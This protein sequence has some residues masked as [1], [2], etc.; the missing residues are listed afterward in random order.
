M[1]EFI[2][3]ILALIS[4][5]LLGCFQTSYILGRILRDLDIRQHGSSNAGASNAVTILGFRWGLVTFLVDFCKAAS[6]VW[7]IR[8]FFPDPPV[9]S[10]LAGAAAV[11]GHIFP[12]FLR[13]R[14]GKGVAAMLGMYMAV[15]PW[16]GVM[17]LVI[18][19]VIAGITD[20]VA[21]GSLAFFALLPL[22]TYFLGYGPFGIGLSILL[23]IIGLVKHRENVIRIRAG[24][25]VKVRPTLFKSCR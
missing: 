12:F 8:W 23:M 11:L 24:T 18:Q 17:I 6:A 9:V 14:G 4:G 21:L 15:Q 7:L 22:L 2:P 13:F 20:Y 16:A 19:I 10:Y 3:Y 1:M 25:E 5:Y